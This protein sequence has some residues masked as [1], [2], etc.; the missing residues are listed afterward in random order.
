MTNIIFIVSGLILGYSLHRAYV[1]RI[2][3]EV[4]L[5]LDK[6]KEIKPEYKMVIAD[7][8]SSLSERI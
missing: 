2:L 1:F 8:L 3:Y 7:M 6:D 4:L 5:K